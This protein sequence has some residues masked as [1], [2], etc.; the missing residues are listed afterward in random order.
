[1]LFIS[2]P[3]L[4]STLGNLSKLKTGTYRIPIQ[5]RLEL[6]VLEL[7]AEH[8]LG[9]PVDVGL[10]VG[11]GD[12]RHSSTRARVGL[13]HVH[14]LVL[15]GELDV[16]QVQG[17]QRQRVLVRVFADLLDHVVVEVSL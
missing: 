9:G 10:A 2:G 3:R 1:M 17:L 12:E 11:L 16:H 6:E 15:H 4:L 14:H 7:G 8:D 5:P 13:D